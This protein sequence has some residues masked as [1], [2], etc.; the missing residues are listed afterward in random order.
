VGGKESGVAAEQAGQGWQEWV[1]VD[2][3]PSAVADLADMVFDANRPGRFYEFADGDLYEVELLR[4]GTVPSV[5]RAARIDCTDIGSLL[6][7]VKGA[8]AVL[9][10]GVQRLGLAGAA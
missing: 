10:A 9:A 5:R 1:D 2:A 6:A 4:P 7:S 3:A 8:R